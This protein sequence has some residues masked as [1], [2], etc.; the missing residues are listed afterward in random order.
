MGKKRRLN[1][2]KAKF[3]AKHANHPRSKLL[4]ARTIEEIVDTPA[5]V[6]TPI[7]RV[8]TTKTEAV[9]KA[10]EEESPVV[11]TPEVVA[12]PKKARRR[13]TKKRTKRPAS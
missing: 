3:K 5:I 4:Q 10:V 6:E 12:P 1:S 11:T 7:I 8:D 2:A 13:T 9:L